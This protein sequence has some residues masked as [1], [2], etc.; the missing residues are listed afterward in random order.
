MPKSGASKPGWCASSLSEHDSSRPPA[1]HSVNH[2]ICGTTGVWSLPELIARY[3]RA[4]SG[5]Y[6]VSW[7]LVTTN[8]RQRRLRGSC[9]PIRRHKG[10]NGHQGTKEMPIRT[11]HV[12]CGNLTTDAYDKPRMT[13]LIVLLAPIHNLSVSMDPTDTTKSMSGQKDRG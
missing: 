5:C 11:C 6:Q 12:S 13:L 7:A 8:K 9:Y 10:D 3:T 2:M 1:S 4:K